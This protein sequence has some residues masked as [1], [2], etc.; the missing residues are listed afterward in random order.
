ME[1]DH[2]IDLLGRELPGYLPHEPYA[3]EILETVR[4]LVHPVFGPLFPPM[5]EEKPEVTE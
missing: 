5:P 1:W 2:Y 3:A 4:G